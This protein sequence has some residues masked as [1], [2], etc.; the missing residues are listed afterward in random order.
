MK[1][2]SH[3]IGIKINSEV[4]VDLFVSLQQYLEKNGLEGIIELQN[5]YSL[6]VTLYYL[7]KEL[8]SEERKDIKHTIQDITQSH[9]D[10]M[11]TG[12]DL[13]YLKKDEKD[14]LGYITCLEVDALQKINEGLALKY[15]Q[16]QVVENQY[17]YIPHIS[18]FR[19]INTEMFEKNKEY[20]K[21]LINKNLDEIRNENL[22]RGFYLFKVNSEFHPEIQLISDLD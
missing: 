22:F 17:M 19:I 9:N 14:Y 20:V 1:I 4:F 2:T 3:F 8:S 16:N 15:K 6:H 18:L 13:S 7:K 21:D 12:G 10:F 5:I 11:L